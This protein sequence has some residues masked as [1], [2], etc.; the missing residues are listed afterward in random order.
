MFLQF[1]TLTLLMLVLFALL[2]TSKPQF[3]TAMSNEDLIEMHSRLLSEEEMESFHR[4]LSFFSAW[5]DFINFIL[6]LFRGMLGGGG[7][8]MGGGMGGTG[9]GMGGGMGG[10]GGGGGM[11]GLNAEEMSIVHYLLD[12]RFSIDRSKEMVTEDGKVVGMKL[13]TTSDLPAVANQIKSHVRQMKALVENGRWV[14]QGDPL[15][16]E[17]LS[18]RDEISIEVNSTIT[19][20]VLVTQRGDS[21]CTVALIQGH[22]E[23]VDGFISEGR[24]EV[25]ANHPV[26]S[27]CLN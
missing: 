19:N 9:G 1:N 3:A 27:I 8:G 22:S 26:P 7:D 12:N 16:Y 23:A 21:E 25:H 4:E 17:L 13:L 24:A 5:D 14:R 15:Y 18:R 6:N 2:S 10:M 20:G 11:M